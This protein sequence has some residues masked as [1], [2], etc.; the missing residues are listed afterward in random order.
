MSKK[1]KP[2]VFTEQELKLEV[3]TLSEEIFQ[4][5]NQLSLNRKLEKPHLLPLK[6]RERA[7]AL[8]RLTQLAKRGA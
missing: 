8:T 2:K 4:L 3:Q 7:R 1:E 5:R 6:K